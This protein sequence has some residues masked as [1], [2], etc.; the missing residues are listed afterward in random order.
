MGQTYKTDFRELSMEVESSSERLITKSEK[1][2]ESVSKIF[3][4]Q[5][6]FCN[7]QRHFEF[8]DSRL[9]CPMVTKMAFL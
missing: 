7:F 8:D 5:R 2:R 1:F 3:E 9:A 6:N 4:N